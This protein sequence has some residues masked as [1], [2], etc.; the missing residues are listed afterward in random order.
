MEMFV[1]DM[2]QLWMSP[3]IVVGGMYLL[4]QQVSWASLVG[5]GMIAITM[6][7][8]AVVY[9]KLNVTLKLNH[10]MKDRRV[11]LLNEV[12]AGVRVI[13]Y[14]A[15]TQPLMERVNATRRK[16]LKY[17]LRFLNLVAI[18]FNLVLGW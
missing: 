12:L 11:K 8:N 6:P 5:L 18:G 4:W 17:V 3:L 7:I 16:E 1:A 14:Y 13:K 2:H 15:W 9:K 10:V